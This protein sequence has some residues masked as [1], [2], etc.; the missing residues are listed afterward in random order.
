ML[1]LFTHKKTRL[2]ME[3][4]TGAFIMLLT[5]KWSRL[6]HAL[7]RLFND[8]EPNLYS[9]IH[10]IFQSGNYITFTMSHIYTTCAPN[11]SKAQDTLLATNSQISARIIYSETL[12]QL[13]D[14]TQRLEAFGKIIMPNQCPFGLKMK[15]TLFIHYINGY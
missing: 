5:S 10:C 11:T 2:I 12:R 1:K 7:R 4:L 15:S 9:K 14:D 6:T 8:R 13:D 3:L